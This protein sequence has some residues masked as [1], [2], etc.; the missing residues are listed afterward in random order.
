[1]VWETIAK[2]PLGTAR[3]G[4]TKSACRQRERRARRR[5]ERRQVCA[6]CGVSFVP[7]RADA[8]FCGVAC[9]QYAYRQRK[10]AESTAARKRADFIASLI[11]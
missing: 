1:M 5:R 4:L 2:Q 10:A 6:G 11:G 8:R 9:R 3:R 7:S